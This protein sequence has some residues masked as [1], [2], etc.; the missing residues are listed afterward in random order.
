MD[1]TMEVSLPRWQFWID[2]GGTFTDALARDPERQLHR[3]KVLSSAVVKGIA[4]Q[5][6]GNLVFD[7]ARGAE[8]PGFWNGYGFR[9]AAD[10]AQ[11]WTI[12]EHAADGTL[13][14]DR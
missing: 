10:S 11:T 4:A 14:L 8:P 9:L 6:Q 12:V 1:T 7:P 3:C 5:V 2:V 13:R